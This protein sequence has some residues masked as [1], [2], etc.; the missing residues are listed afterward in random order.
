MA[1]WGSNLLERRGL[2]DPNI[3]VPS[4]PSRRSGTKVSIIRPLCSTFLKS[5]IG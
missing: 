4:I 3:S 1:Y 5:T 2:C